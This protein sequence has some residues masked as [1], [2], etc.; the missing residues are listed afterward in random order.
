MFMICLPC[1]FC[2][3]GYAVLDG[4]VIQFDPSRVGQL[5][6]TVPIAMIV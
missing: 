2:H 3:S 5:A 6:G 4:V 1:Q